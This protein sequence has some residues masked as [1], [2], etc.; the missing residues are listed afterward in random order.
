MVLGAIGGY[1]PL[2]RYTAKHHHLARGGLAHT[3]HGLAAVAFSSIICPDVS[4]M[5]HGVI[6]LETRRDTT[7]ITP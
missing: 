5:D 6:D 3:R 7:S 2:E 4:K 1:R